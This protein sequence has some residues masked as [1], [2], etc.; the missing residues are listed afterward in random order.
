MS[1]VFL[2]FLSLFAL[3]IGTGQDLIEPTDV[4]NIKA[5]VIANVNGGINVNPAP[6]STLSI[7]GTIEVDNDVA[8]QIKVKKVIYN[9][10][11]IVYVESPVTRLRVDR[12]ESNLLSDNWAVYDWTDNRNCEDFPEF[13]IDMTVLAPNG[14]PI[15]ISTI[16]EGSI[17][18]K[19]MEGPIWVNNINGAIELKN[20]AT[21]KH[22]KTINGDVDLF[23]KDKVDT[24]GDFYTLNG[25]INAY[26]TPGTDLNLSFKS[27]SGDFYTDMDLESLP[28]VS[29]KKS[30]TSGFTFKLDKSIKLKM[31][32]GGALHK[33]ETFNGDAIIRTSKG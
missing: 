4:S 19:N 30:K 15:S 5:I 24:N 33:F 25:N 12:E 3:C 1:K 10:T 20:I 22:A 7:K 18:V 11:L 26:Y 32:R 9:D 21:I 6:G 13:K 28:S 31:G 16:N 8:N 23:F 14:I 27:F 29:T 2:T 17:A